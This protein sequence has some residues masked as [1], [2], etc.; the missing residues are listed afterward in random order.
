MNIEYLP[1]R[2]AQLQARVIPETKKPR[3]AM[4]RKEVLVFF[5]RKSESLVK[6]KWKYFSRQEVKKNF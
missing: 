3:L 6:T 5:S 2:P 1:A 4:L